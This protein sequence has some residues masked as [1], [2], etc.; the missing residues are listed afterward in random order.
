MITPARRSSLVLRLALALLVMVAA[1]IGSSA[2]VGWRLTRRARPPFEE[3]LPGGL[4]HTRQVTIRTSDGEQLGAWFVEGRPDR[5]CFLL[6]HGNGGARRSWTVFLS[7]LEQHGFSALIPSLRAHG[8]ST[9]ELNDFGWSAR[10]DVIACVQW[11][12]ERQPPGRLIVA[13]T[14]LG[15]VAAIHAAPELEGVSG[16]YLESPYPTLDTAMRRRLD[17]YLPPLFD[18][19]AACG[20]R[21]CSYALLDHDPELD[22][23]LASIARMPASP[24]VRLLAFESDVLA[25]PADARRIAAAL[26]RPAETTILSGAGHRSY[27]SR[28]PEAFFS[29]LTELGNR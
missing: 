14:S 1:W 8:G 17:E 4:R 11:L 16:Y 27:G 24:E 20:L 2:G 23:P 3:P 29:L 25:P 13:G 15:A 21:L 22:S 26:S 5:P 9:G 28:D 12:R 10:H 6:L 7:P 18:S 19:L